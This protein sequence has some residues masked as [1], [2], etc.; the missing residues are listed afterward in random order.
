MNS[1]FP[2]CSG[3]LHWM[4]DKSMQVFTFFHRFF[5]RVFTALFLFHS[6]LG[7]GARRKRNKKKCRGCS[8]PMLNAT[9]VSISI[10]VS[11]VAVNRGMEYTRTT[12]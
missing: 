5:F 10:C 11:V 7:Y 3:F 9:A 2:C 1:A 8:P 4:A 12:E 6:A